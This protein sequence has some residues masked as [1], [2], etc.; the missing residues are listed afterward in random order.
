MY[1]VFFNER[2]ITLSSGLPENPKNHGAQGSELE[3][4]ES[5][6]EIVNL[7]LMSNKKEE[8]LVYK[9]ID[10]LWDGFKNCFL[11]IKAAG[12]V[13]RKDNKFLFI[14]RRGK[15]DLPKGKIDKGESAKRAALREVVEECGISNMKIINQLPSTWHIYQS[16]YPDSKNKWILKETSWFE[17][18]YKGTQDLKPQTEEDITDIMWVG[19]NDF[20]EIL[21]NTYP[22]LEQ[23]IRLYL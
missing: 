13:V 7:F 3:H 23:I 5:L 21:K 22:N 2:K 8:C 4:L 9:N 1:K 15:W 11:C 17:M 19:E 14:F 16:P 6:P 20:K 18:D 12:G 10:D